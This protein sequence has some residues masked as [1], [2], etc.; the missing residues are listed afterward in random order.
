MEVM[1]KHL[2]STSL[3]ILDKVFKLSLAKFCG[4]GSGRI[5]SKDSIFWS[6]EPDSRLYRRMFSQNFN[7]LQSIPD[8]QNDP[9]A[10]EFQRASNVLPLKF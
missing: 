1:Q 7:N 5:I 6:A 9:L 8:E 10:Q 4:I 2:L 3:D